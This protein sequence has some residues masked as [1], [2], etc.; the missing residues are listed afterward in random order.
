MAHRGIK[1]I[2]DELWDLH[3]SKD[4]D[5]AGK[6]S[7]SNFRVCERFGV[8][9]WKG[10]AIRMSDKW[11]RFMSLMEKSGPSVKDESLDDTLKDLIVYAAIVLV[12]RKEIENQERNRVPNS[13]NRAGS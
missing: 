11:S 9:G 6:E 13:Q 1:Q 3:Q 2:F 4:S 5:Y 10:A 12:L 8:P 7:L